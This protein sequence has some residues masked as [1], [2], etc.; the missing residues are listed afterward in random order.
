[1]GEG[2]KD[3]PPPEIYHTYP[4]VMQHDRV[5]PYLQKIQKQINHVT[6]HLASGGISIFQQKP[7]IFV[8]LKNTVIDYILIQILSFA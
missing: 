4:M 1:M 6:H 5:I 2:G 7:S 8:T 3:P